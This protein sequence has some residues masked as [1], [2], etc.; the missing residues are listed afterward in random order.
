MLQEDDCLQDIEATHISQAAL[1]NARM[2]YETQST[3][4]TALH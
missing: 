2:E 3:E 1:I 4:M